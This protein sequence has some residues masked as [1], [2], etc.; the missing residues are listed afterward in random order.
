MPTT[1]THNE[2]GTTT[3]RVLCMAFELSDNTW[4]LGCTTG[5]GHKPRAR[6][7][8][9]RDQGRVLQAIAQAK[10]RCGLPASAPV[11]SG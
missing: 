9:A 6:A 3:E 2:Y 7:V 5:P 10:R 8:A 11:V 4:Q 1:A